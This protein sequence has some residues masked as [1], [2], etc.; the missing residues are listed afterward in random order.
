MQR[1][2][3]VLLFCLL[4]V[5]QAAAIP[6]QRK[7][8]VVLQPDGKR[9]TLLVH[10]D[11]NFGYRTTL[12]GIPVM[13][14]AAGH[15]VY[16]REMQ[17]NKVSLSLLSPT[18]MLA[19]DAEERTPEEKQLVA[20]L[21]AAQT[22]ALL[23][24]TM[25]ERNVARHAARVKYRLQRQ[26]PLRARGLDAGTANPVSTIGSGMA[27]QGKK[28]GLIILAQ[29][30][31][32]KMKTPKV[33]E[34][35]D[36][37]ANLKG[38]SK[39]GHVGSVRDY[40]YDQS[41]GKFD[42][43][44]DVVG[45]VTVSNNLNYYGQND[46]QGADLNAQKLIVEACRLAD[47]MVDYKQ[48]DWNNDGEVEQVYVVYAGYAEAA[49]AP[50]NTIW[51][52]Q[53]ELE[54]SLA[55]TLDGQ[56]IISYACSSELEGNSGSEMSGIGVICH[57]FSHCL[58]LPDFY[59]TSGNQDTNFGM[60]A[61]SIMDYGA[62]NAEGRVPAAYTAYERWYMGWKNLIELNQP[63]QVKDMKAI[64]DGGE[65]YVIYNDAH[66]SECYILDNHQHSKWDKHSM[67][68]GLL[69]THIDY[70]HM[71][72]AENRPN[73]VSTHQRVTPIP[74][75][76]TLDSDIDSY[77]GDLWPGSSGNDELTDTSSPMAKLYNP[78]Q[79]G[80]YLMG[81]PITRITEKDGLIS[82][83]F[84]GGRVFTLPSNLHATNV[85]RTGFTANWDAAPQ[86]ASYDIE[87]LRK[88]PDSY[89]F[90][91]GVLEAFSKMK[92]N[93][94][95]QDGT[96]DIG[97]ELD[98]HMETSG[99]TGENL[100]NSHRKL[101]M[102]SSSKR[103]KLV[104]ATNDKPQEGKVTVAVGALPYGNNSQ[105]KINVRL[106]DSNSGTVLGQ[107]TLTFS[108]SNLIAAQFSNITESYRVELTTERRAYL[109][110]VGVF[111]RAYTA[112]ELQDEHYSMPYQ[113]I[114]VKE[115]L[116]GTSRSFTGLAEGDYAFRV[117]MRDAEEYISDWT[118]QVNVSMLTNIE[119]PATTSP[120][121]QGA[122]F[123][124]SGRRITTP[125][126]GI[127]IQ[128]GQKHVAQ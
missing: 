5:G 35:F 55:L 90:H 104:S 112:D 100:Y 53:W 23:H 26:G 4:C 126:K 47:P 41:D 45:P 20:T 102:G 50:E 11:E 106:I 13:R 39:N 70:D 97:K 58:G 103:G 15:Y 62:Y 49:N 63:T 105:A 43:S 124:L 12:D 66:R 10:G 120:S 67:G 85:T 59:D 98:Q 84:M 119:A 73:N 125:W 61:W 18:Q 16:A 37:C 74:A 99:W 54:P 31:D 7:P 52:H 33:R 110:F 107:Q 86:A 42:V 40:F 22:V 92:G 24:R 46:A 36:Q 88:N 79:K 3:H 117:R 122:R 25:G 113:S 28:K 9:L 77:Q 57:E 51:P 89:H 82:F 8:A 65:A 101:K 68:T 76:G 6:A 96:K 80:S 32:V 114:E 78:N 93:K 94:Q 121:A 123:D 1:I 111:N 19:H 2:L 69:I 29:F 115:Q 21:N 83:A 91:L 30:K 75:D 34:A 128:K 60:G 108:G 109:Y 64:T 44:F 17:G 127:Y 72:W 118:E 38:Y 95:G 81:K 27:V 71:A 87:L 14:N 56:K 48:Y 116:M